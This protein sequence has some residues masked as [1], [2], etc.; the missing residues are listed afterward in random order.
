MIE[1]QKKTFVRRLWNMVSRNTPDFLNIISG[2]SLLWLI[3]I[4]SLSLEKRPITACLV[5]CLWCVQLYSWT[6]RKLKWTQIHTSDNSPD[7]SSKSIGDYRRMRD[8][9]VWYFIFLGLYWFLW[10]YYITKALADKTFLGSSWYDFSL[11]AIWLIPEAFLFWGGRY[12]LSIAGKRLSQAEYE[13]YSA[14]EQTK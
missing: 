14:K 1:E 3:V 5:F 13:Y 7:T 12:L 9:H 8:T 4:L 10:G 11:F 2:L 6:Y